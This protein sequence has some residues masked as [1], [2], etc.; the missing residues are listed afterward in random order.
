MREGSTLIVVA[1]ALV[2][3]VLAV[4]VVAFRPPVIVNVPGPST[5]SPEQ[6]HV[7]AVGAYPTCYWN[8][9]ASEFLVRFGYVNSGNRTARNAVANLTYTAEFGNA[10]TYPFYKDINFGD[11]AAHT[12]GYF[13]QAGA[14]SV[15]GVIACGRTFDFRVTFTWTP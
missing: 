7:V 4:L 11:I 8:G 10:T 6:A 9:T 2:V 14:W 13:E 5:E 3:V 15:P 12:T 1:G